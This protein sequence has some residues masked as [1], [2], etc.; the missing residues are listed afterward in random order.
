MPATAITSMTTRMAV[1]MAMFAPVLVA[2]APTTARTE[3][4]S[5]TTP[6]TALIYAA[7]ISQP[8]RNPR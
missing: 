7:I 5:T 2:S 1:L 8:V 4:A 3:G 6:V